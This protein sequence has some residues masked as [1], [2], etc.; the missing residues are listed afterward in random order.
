MG[1]TRGFC[2]YGYEHSIFFL[3][4]GTFYPVEGCNQ[5][6]IEGID[7]LEFQLTE[8]PAILQLGYTPETAVR[9]VAA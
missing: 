3:Q 2:E 9:E 1:I 5:P 8:T 6:L 4:H 7:P